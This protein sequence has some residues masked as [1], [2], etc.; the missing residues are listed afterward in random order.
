MPASLSAHILIQYV[1]R[2]CS[3]TKGKNPPAKNFV[4]YQDYLGSHLEVM[5][6]SSGHRMILKSE[7]GSIQCPN[8]SKDGKSLIYN[9][10]EGLLYNYNIGSGIAKQINSGFA[11][12][13][14]NDHVI[15]P[16]GKMIA[17]SNYVGPERKSTI[18]IMPL[19]GTDNPIKISSEDSGHSYLHSWSPDGKNIIFTGQRNDEWDIWSINIDTKKEKNLTNFPGLDDGSEYSPDGKWI[20]FNASPDRNNADMEDETRRNRTGTNYI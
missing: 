11:I 1:N 19:E 2:L 8:W 9:S 7:K 3:V 13:N 14:N 12:Q 6:I 10:A 5:D 15:S 20:F 18:F 17:I 16:D 4:P